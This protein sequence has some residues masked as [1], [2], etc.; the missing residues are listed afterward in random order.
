VSK[1]LFRV[2]QDVVSVEEWEADDS[3]ADKYTGPMPQRGK[4]Y[5]IRRIVLETSTGNIYV[6]LVGFDEPWFDQDGFAP[7]E[8][9]PNESLAELLEEVLSLELA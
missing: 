3:G 1:S 4:I 5:R 7:V 9:L 2:G 6:A 8:Y